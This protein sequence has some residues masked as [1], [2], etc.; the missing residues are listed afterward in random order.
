M[1]YFGPILHT[2]ACEHYLT[3]GMC[4]S[5]FDG[6]KFAEHHFSQLSFDS[7]MLIIFEPHSIF[8][9]LRQTDK[10]DSQAKRKQRKRE[11]KQTKTNK[12]KQN[13]H[14]LHEIIA[15]LELVNAQH[16]K[17]HP[18]HT[19]ERT[20]H[21]TTT[22]PPPK[23]RQQPHNHNKSQHK[24]RATV[25]RPV[26]HHVKWRFAGGPIVA[27]CYMLTGS[28]HAGLWLLRLETSLLQNYVL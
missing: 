19:L 9:L 22:I 21:F 6:K 12:Q 13:S 17:P 8:D 28:L 3:I 16:H 7:E 14:F 25:S 15:T 11:K 23:N 27:R 10:I 18:I 24:S 5:I 4:N 1:V 2:N 20:K 26:K